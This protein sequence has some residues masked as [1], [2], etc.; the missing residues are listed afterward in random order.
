M[1]TPSH[2]DTSPPL[3][4]VSLENHRE[5][6]YNKAVTYES[7]GE[8]NFARILLAVIP[9]DLCRPLNHGP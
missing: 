5:R 1:Q 8:I 6:T 3:P 9:G 4:L 2:G 7:T